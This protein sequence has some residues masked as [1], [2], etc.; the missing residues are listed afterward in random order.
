MAVLSKEDFMKRVQERIGEDSSDEALS[1]VED[2]SDT[3]NDME[4]RTNGVNE[5]EWQKKLDDLDAS[6]R[7]K[8]KARFFEGQTTPQEA[9]EEQTEDIKDDGESVTFDDL[10]EEREG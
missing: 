7:D 3:Y 6:W 10:F 2:M 5:E 4:T 1:F 8:Y 9:K